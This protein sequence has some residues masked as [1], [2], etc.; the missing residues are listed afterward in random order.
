[1]FTKKYFI[2]FLVNNSTFGNTHLAVLKPVCNN[3]NSVSSAI[4][5]HPPLQ[6]RK[7][8]VC[9]NP[10]ISTPVGYL[11]SFKAVLPTISSGQAVK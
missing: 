9:S 11:I 7:N 2:T 10:T 6:K 4:H 1:M 3:Y 8:L 5:H